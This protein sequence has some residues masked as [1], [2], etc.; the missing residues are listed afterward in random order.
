MR[1]VVKLWAV[2]GKW[3]G[4]GREEMGMMESL[5]VEGGK[6]RRWR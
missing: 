3:G 2:L 1:G 6:I 4:R 5:I